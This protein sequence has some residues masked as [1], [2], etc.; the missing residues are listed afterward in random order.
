VVELRRCSE[1]VVNGPDVLNPEVL[2]EWLGEALGCAITHVV[3]EQLP[4]GYANGA[5][6]LDV[7]VAGEV[8]RMVLK[9]P[10]SPSVVYRLDPCREARVVA[11]LARLGAPVPAVLAIDAGTRAVGRPCFVM[12]YVEGYSVPDA[13]PGGY[14]GPGWY[15]DADRSTQRAIWD[16]FHDAL[17]AV[18]R[19]D[20]RSLA[21]AYDGPSGAVDV[22]RYWRDALLDVV[23][24]EQ[25]PRQLA[26][27]EWLLDSIP[28]SAKEPPAVC[29]GDARLVNAVVKGAEVRALVDFEV[30]YVGNPAADVGYSLFLDRSQRAHD[31]GPLPG[32]P[33]EEE[34]W[35]RWSEVT[36]R[37]LA[38]VEYWSAFG[39]G[40]IVVTAT[41]AMVQWGLADPFVE[42]VNTLVPAWESLVDRAAR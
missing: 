8:R 25:A 39:A 5:W 16:S 15:R 32:V 3:V 42:E 24:A 23:T 31:D 7:T 1:S 37:A 21:D 4:G 41:R 36:G 13:V 20:P 34:T 33:S 38:D 17:G 27:F 22:L 12:E 9:A 18:H 40:V 35:A 26:M 29:M 11:R 30:A 6:R 19:I 14:H 28:S 2:R 10:R